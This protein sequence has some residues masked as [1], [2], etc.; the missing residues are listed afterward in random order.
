MFCLDI[1]LTNYL[2]FTKTIIPLT[3]MGPES[4]AHSTFSLRPHGLLTHSPFGLKDKFTPFHSSW[5]IWTQQVD[6]A[7]NV[8]LHSSVGRASHQYFMVV[9]GLNPIEALI[10]SGFFFPIL[11]LKLENSLRWSFFT[12]IYHHSSHMNY[13]II[14]HA[15]PIMHKEII[16]SWNVHD[17]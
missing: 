15:L 12:F 2:D 8:R 16:L 11:L 1:F 7:P 10:F 4:I 9:T 14:L 3:L 13:C 6:L 17:C 5:E